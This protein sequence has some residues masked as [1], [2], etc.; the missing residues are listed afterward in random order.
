MFIVGARV[1]T[2]IMN[3]IYKKALKLST[4]ARRTATVG[5]MTNLLSVNAQMLADLTTYLNIVWSAPLQ[6]LLSLFMLYQY[7]GISAVIGK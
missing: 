6:I 7:L 5:E 2:S 3:I 1:R 4:S